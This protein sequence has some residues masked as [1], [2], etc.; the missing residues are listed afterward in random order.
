MAIDG[1]P[2]ST[3]QVFAQRDV[4][5]TPSSNLTQTQT[6]LAPIG[7]VMPWLKSFTNT[8]ALIDGWE[9]CNGQ[10]LSDADSIYNGQ[11]LPDLNGNN[12]FLR[13]NSTSGATGG[14][15][16]MAHTHTTNVTI[17]N[18]TALA[19]NTEAAHTHSNGSFKLKNEA[20]TGGA[21]AQTTSGTGLAEVTEAGA[22]QVFILQN[23]TGGSLDWE[24]ELFNN[25]EGTSSAGSA[26]GHTFSQNID[27][28]TEN[29]PASSAASNDE[30][31]P[32]FYNVVWIMR[33]K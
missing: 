32:P 14:S 17:D 7:A 23:T 19:L 28:H 16:T 18:H 22:A 33:I 2:K 30:N 8:P 12:Q 31:R 27:A 24:G 5:R 21:N 9:E 10:V 25:V 13:G 11:T 29:N 15:E 4:R 26:H 1:L 3:P 6:N 20:G